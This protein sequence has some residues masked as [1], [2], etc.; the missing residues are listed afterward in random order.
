VRALAFDVLKR[1]FGLILVLCG[2]LTIIFIIPHLAPGGPERA[3]IGW[4][5]TA[6][7]AA[8]LRLHYGG[9]GVGRSLPGALSCARSNSPCRSPSSSWAKPSA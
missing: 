3:L 5:Y 6:E 4:P 1:L 2:V 9:S 8:A 7:R